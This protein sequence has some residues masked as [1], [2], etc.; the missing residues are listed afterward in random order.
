LGKQLVAVPGSNKLSAGSTQV[1]R[2]STATGA[3]QRGFQKKGV[4]KQSPAVKYAIIGAIVVALAAAAYFAK[5]YIPFFK[6]ADEEAASTG[7]GK[8]GAGSGEGASE[9]QP[10]TP[11][12]PK[13]IP[14]TPPVYTLDLTKAKISEGKV[15]GTIAGT[16]F[17]PDNVRLDKLAGTYVLNM[18]QG[19]GQSPDRGLMVYMHLNPTESPTGHTWAVS[20]DM[21]GTEIS[22][23]M[24]V[25]KPNPRYAATQKS[26]STGFALKLEFGQLTESN[27]IPGRIFVALPDAEQSV[28]GGAFNAVTTVPGAPE[29]VAQPEAA[30]SQQSEADRNAFQR[31]YGIRPR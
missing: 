9:G 31:R 24:K 11:P 15:N 20:Q 6:K 23:V 2:S 17:V 19:V 28:V 16:N 3:P 12:P 30:Q 1:A 26:F 27:T 25:W 8:K 29:A 21:R 10:E 18:R 5:P 4:K 7:G 14:M 13:V 22:Q